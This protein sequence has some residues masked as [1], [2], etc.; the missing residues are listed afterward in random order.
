MHDRHERK[1]FASGTRILLQVYE[2]PIFHLPLL[3]IVGQRKVGK[4]RNENENDFFL[5]GVDLD[6]FLFGELVKQSCPCKGGEL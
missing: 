2:L 6:V 4:E 1:I 3:S 5:Q